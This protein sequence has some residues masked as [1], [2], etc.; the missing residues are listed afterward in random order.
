MVYAIRELAATSRNEKV[1][2]WALRKDFYKDEDWQSD[3]FIDVAENGHI[4]ILELADRKELHWYC[5]KILVGAVAR[6]NL[7]L[8]DFILNKKPTKFNLS[9]TR[10]CPTEG[11]IVW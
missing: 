8:L 7:E 5:R 4:K 11:F 10:M 2:K 3:I 6:T 1:F 9:L